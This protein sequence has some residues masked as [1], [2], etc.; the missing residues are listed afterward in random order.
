MIY[1]QHGSAEKKRI[2]LLSL[3]L[4]PFFRDSKLTGVAFS[5]AS[6]TSIKVPN[7]AYRPTDLTYFTFRSNILAKTVN[8]RAPTKSLTLEFSLPLPQ[9]HNVNYVTRQTNQSC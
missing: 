6:D 3:F 7:P 8:C 9:S 1:Y 5:D 2:P 4:V